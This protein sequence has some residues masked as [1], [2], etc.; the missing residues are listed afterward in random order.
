MLYEFIAGLLYITVKK[1]HEVMLYYIE[2]IR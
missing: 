1:K 2:S